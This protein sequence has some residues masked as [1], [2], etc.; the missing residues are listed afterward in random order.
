MDRQEQAIRRLI[1]RAFGAGKIVRSLRAQYR[2]SRSMVQQVAQNP[3]V[4]EELRALEAARDQTVVSVWAKAEE[5]AL[6]AMDTVIETFEDP[7]VKPS[8]RIKAAKFTLERAGYG[9]S[10]AAR[11]QQ[12]ANVIFTGEE[13]SREL[14]PHR[15]RMRQVRDESA[16]LTIEAEVVDINSVT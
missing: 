13:V 11:T 6:D 3:A 10:S 16:G 2:V 5:K 8:D 15:A 14:R 4:Q 7:T 12:N 1:I 9:T